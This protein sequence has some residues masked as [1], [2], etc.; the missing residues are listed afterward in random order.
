[1]HGMR[2]SLSIRAGALGMKRR[3]PD[4]NRLS[5]RHHVAG[6]LAVALLACLGC[7]NPIL[8]QQSPEARL[9]LPPTPD[10]PLIAEYT[11]PYGMNYTKVEAV[12]MVTGLPGTGSDP[13]PSPQRATLLDDMNRRGVNHPNDVLASPGTSLV[14]VRAY[15][16]PGIQKGD[17]FDVEVRVPS[18]SETTNLRSGWLLPARLTEMAVLGE[19]IRQGSVLGQAEGPVLVDPAADPKKDPA[20]ATRGRVLGGG[21]ALKSRSLGLIVS[22]QH[23]SIRLSQQ[24]SAAINKRFYVHVDGRKQGVAVPKTEEFIELAVHARYKDNVGRFMRVARNIPVDESTKVLQDRLQLLEHQLADPLTAA[25]AAIRLEAVGNDQAIEILTKALAINDPEVRFYAAE[26]LAYLDQTAAVETLAAVARDEPSFR[27]NALAALSAMDDVIAFD[28]LRDLLSVQS[29]E[30]RYGAFRALWA[31]NENDPL[32]RGETMGSGFT[33]HVL[34]V[35][36]PAMIHVTQ[37]YRPE[38]VVFG[39]NQKFSLPL[40]L[41]AGPNVLVNGQ[42]GGK[43]IVSRFTP[44]HEPEQR[45]VSTSVDD[46]VRAIVDLGGTYPDV[47]QALQQAKHDGA[48]Q[49]RFLVDA[50]PQSGRQYDREAAKY[51]ADNDF[52]SPETDDEEMPLDVSTPLPDLFTQ[53][54]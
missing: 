12:S 31:M 9:D 23:Q 40:V 21:V 45:T 37:S 1:M 51:K 28:S 53:Q 26:A 19:Q 29:A 5:I 27:V 7:M 17:H 25:N 34:D 49:S 4:D 38:V 2:Q 22:R 54:R 3:A 32:V 30:T 20:L 35:A 11:H 52:E 50:L 15:L 24:I 10:V 46:V 14:L 41:D 16:R 33:Y 48:L 42:S 18:R 6:W 8:R 44:G 39:K 43:I 36:G 47:V 13:P